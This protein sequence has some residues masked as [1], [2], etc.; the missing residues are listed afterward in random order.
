MYIMIKYTPDGN[1]VH[2]YYDQTHT[3]WDIGHG[4][5][6][7]AEAFTLDSIYEIIYMEKVRKMLTINA[8][9]SH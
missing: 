9:T 5:Y 7:T 3:W 8:T 2:V 1:C 6:L 4:Q